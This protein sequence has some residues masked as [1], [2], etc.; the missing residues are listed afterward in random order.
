MLALETDITNWPPE[1]TLLRGEVTALLQAERLLSERYF[2]GQPLLFPSRAEDLADTLT[3]LDNLGEVYESIREG[4]PPQSEADFARWLLG[5]A[6]PVTF[7]SSAPGA[8]S[9]RL[10][11]DPRRA[12]R[13]LDEHFVLLARAEALADMGERNASVGLVQTGVQAQQTE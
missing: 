10:R 6:G 1:E 7:S 3:S 12:A 13:A 5:E 4:R 8:E 9:D 2:C 11:T